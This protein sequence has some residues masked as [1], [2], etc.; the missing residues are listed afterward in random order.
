M[1]TPG[2]EVV[3]T[4]AEVSQA[5]ERRRQYEAFARAADQRADMLPRTMIAKLGFATADL[6]LMSIVNRTVKP[7]TAKEAIEVAKIALDIA[8][9]E[10]GET[11]VT[12]TI[13]TAEQ[14]QAAL[15]R[16]GQMRTAAQA[17]RALEAG[18]PIEDAVV[19]DEDLAF[20][21]SVPQIV[22]YGEPLL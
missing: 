17:R 13:K 12:I 2:Q 1:E 19:I 15:E 7:K 9:R 16:I 10:E 3:A 8:R 11:D 21:P 22:E 4:A 6:M 5:S 20:Q 14:R 18:P